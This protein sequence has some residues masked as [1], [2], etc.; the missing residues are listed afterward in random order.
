MVVG[1]LSITGHQILWSGGFFKLVLSPSS[2]C[3]V[4][5][6]KKLDPMPII[7]SSLMNTA[8]I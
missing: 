4:V 7:L 8:Y 3:L 6:F 1:Y 5:V 2:F